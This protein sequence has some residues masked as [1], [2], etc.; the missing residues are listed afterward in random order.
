MKKIILAAAL[1][2]TSSISMAMTEKG[3]WGL[4]G[5]KNIFTI[6]ICHYQRIETFDTIRFT[7]NAY[8]IGYG[9]CVAPNY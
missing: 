3:P 6:Y 5:I 1:I 7:N 2:M 9:S 8:T 4:V